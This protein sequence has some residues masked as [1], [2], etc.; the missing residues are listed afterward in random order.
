MALADEQGMYKDTMNLMKSGASLFKEFIEA[1]M[2][3]LEKRQEYASARALA[4][5]I[6]AGKGM[7][8]YTVRGDCRERVAE[9]LKAHNIPYQM[10]KGKDGSVVIYI[11]NK[12]MEQ[13]AELNHKIL[14]SMSNY[15]QAVP[16]VDLEDSIHGYGNF[17]DNEKKIVCLTGLE[18]DIA[19][20]IRN[21]SNDITK[22][23]MVGFTDP[24]EN[25]KCDVGV[26]SRLT[27]TKDKKH[28][29]CHAILAASLSLYGPNHD[30]KKKQLEADDT[31]RRD[32]ARISKEG[33]DKTYSS[34]YVCGANDRH[35]Y[36]ELTDN[37][38]QYYERRRQ[39]DGTYKDIM[40]FSCDKSDPSYN[41]ELLKYCDVIQ[42]KVIVNSA[43]ELSDFM[44]GRKSLTSD[45]P[46]KDARQKQISDTET[47]LTDAIDRSVRRRTHRDRFSK[48][49]VYNEYIL[50]QKMDEY[51][52]EV[53]KIVDGLKN[54]TVPIGYTNA[55]M[56]V[57]KEIL[58][59]GNIDIN[60]YKKSVDFMKNINV[61]V[62]QA[63]S[64]AEFLYN[65]EKTEKEKADRGEETR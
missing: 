22:G 43:D 55:D 36:I 32:L 46:E 59:S 1:L 38:F 12:D 44:R 23:F 17:S 25:G 45:R 61:E 20:V 53:E 34:V 16:M 29:F 28:D 56:D 52:S 57:L 65:K 7:C 60:D 63:K 4:R 58:K 48:N 19:S 37:D 8:V 11:R 9:T 2:A 5:W 21:K 27:M 26:H 42:D 10:Q 62:H 40:K 39:P 50:K 13:C 15:Y 31:I 3:Y 14:E 18:S 54:D 24:D 33:S 49:D 30:L 35:R 6:K 41:G 47:M 64:R 51:F